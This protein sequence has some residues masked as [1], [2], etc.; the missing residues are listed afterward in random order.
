MEFNATFLATIITF[1]VFVLLMNKILYAPIL[2][3]MEERQSFIKGNYKVAEEN[4]LKTSELI[5][6]KEEML[7]EAKENARDCYNETLDEYK[8]QRVEIISDAQVVAN[9]ELEHSRIELEN[10][11]NEIK[12]ALKGSMINL[13][14][15]IVEK[16]IGYKSEVQGFD[17]EAVNNIFYR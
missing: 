17:D 5:S 4:D 10:V 1:V 3:I 6:E 16:V 13:A 14:N 11:S 2:N 8:A 7:A 15:D 12:Q 9:E